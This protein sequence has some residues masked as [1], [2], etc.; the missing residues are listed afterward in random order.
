[1][2][3][4]CSLIV[5]LLLDKGMFVKLVVFV[6]L[7]RFKLDLAALARISGF[8]K[9]KVSYGLDNTFLTCDQGNFN[10]TSAR[11]RNEL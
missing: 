2:L 6:L 4:A 10:Q 3:F 11:S 1:M 9:G 7:M 5:L 8:L